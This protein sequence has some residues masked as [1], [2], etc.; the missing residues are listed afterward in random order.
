MG[1][2]M[3]IRDSLNAGRLTSGTIPDARFP[4]VLP[5]IDGSNLTNISASGDITAVVAGTGLSGGA[6]SGSATL[7]LDVALGEQVAVFRHKEANNTNTGSFTAGS[8]QTRTLNFE[9]H[10]D[11]SGCSLNTSTGEFDLPAGTYLIYFSAGAF[12]V[13]NHRAKIVTDGGTNKILGDN[14]RSFSGDSSTTHSIGMGVVT[15]ASTEGYFLKHR[16][17]STRSTNGVGLLGDF[18]AEEEFYATVVVF[19]MA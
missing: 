3:C 19:K 18:D 5:A 6:T 16:C 4:S 17:S 14:A 8:D 2:E 13:N 1:S 9:E 7:N 11:I 10:N 12:D 15:N